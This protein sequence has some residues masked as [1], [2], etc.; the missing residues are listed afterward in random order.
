M[1]IFVPIVKIEERDDGTLFVAGIASS[2]ALDSQGEV[3]TSD[4][5]KAALPDFFKYGTGNLREMHQPIAA[6]RVDKAE[7][8]EDGKTYIECVVVDPIAVKKVQ[9]NVYKGFSVGGR[10]TE[11]NDGVISGLRLSEISLV[12]RPA[13]PEAVISVWKADGMDDQPAEQPVEVEKSLWTAKEIIEAL[14]CMRN[15][16]NSAEWEAKEGEKSE[17]MVTALKDA[18][19][20]IGDLAQRYL[21]EEM[22]PP[23]ASPAVEMADAGGDVEKA[24]A[25]FSRTTKAS[26]AKIQGML[27]DCDKMMTDLGYESAEEKSDAE[28]DLVK[29][30]AVSDDVLA[31]AKAAGLE[32]ADGSLY[33]DIAKAALADLAKAQARVKELEAQPETPKAS[34]T[35]V[36]KGADVKDGLHSDTP[37]AN[38]NDPLAMMKAALSR[39]MIIGAAPVSK[40]SSAT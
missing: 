15:V 37:A 30:D 33:A 7:V 39:P 35:A 4:A 8:G 2:E 6:G 12:D 21:A 23:A 19:K 25:T 28:T 27:R 34:L 9:E 10:A 18:V 38:P 36:E 16:A 5:M 20:V 14:G 22:N 40:P 24:G 11:K 26:L 17:A 32:L 13:N 29:A 1:K 3:I 31:L